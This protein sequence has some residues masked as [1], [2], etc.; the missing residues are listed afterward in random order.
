M[1]GKP[2]STDRLASGVHP[3]VNLGIE[4]AASPRLAKDQVNRLAQL[5]AQSEP[6]PEANLGSHELSRCTRTEWLERLAAL[7][8]NGES[9]VP[10][11]ITVDETNLLLAKVARKRRDRLVRFIA[12]AIASDIQ[13]AHEI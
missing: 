6:Q 10:D 11:S 2:I 13:R 9:P 5:E 7:V 8:A 12:R 3:R 1:S 4:S